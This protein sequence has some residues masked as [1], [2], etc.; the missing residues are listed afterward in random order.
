MKALK[1]K[2]KFGKGKKP[3]NRN[4][5]VFGICDGK[6]YR[7]QKRQ[8]IKQIKH[9]LLFCIPLDE[10]EIKYNDLWKLGLQY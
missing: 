9:K 10:E 5:K 3:K 2:R 7:K 1:D 8:L 4:C 6:E